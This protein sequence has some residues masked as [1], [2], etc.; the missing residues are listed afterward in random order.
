MPPS[1]EQLN[2]ILEL[3][4]EL[5]LLVGRSCTEIMRALLAT[6]TLRSLGQTGDGLLDEPQARA[7]IQILENWIWKKKHEH[8]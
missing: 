8:Q 5:H 3:T 7:C 4:W 2:R 6:R 1:S